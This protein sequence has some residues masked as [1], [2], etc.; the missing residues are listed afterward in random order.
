VCR[1]VTSVCPLH[2]SVTSVCTLRIG[3][4]ISVC[5][6]VTCVC[7]LHMSVTSVWT[8]LI[9]AL[10]LLCNA[11]FGPINSEIVGVH[12]RGYKCV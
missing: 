7:P 3:G 4:G 11:T 10:I 12:R 6:Y 1:Y 5:R 8:L 2:M 9:S